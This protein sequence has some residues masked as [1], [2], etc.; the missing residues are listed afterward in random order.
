MFLT[1]AFVPSFRTR[2]SAW[3][4]TQASQQI[5]RPDPHRVTVVFSTEFSQV[6]CM[7]VEEQLNPHRGI[8]ML[9]G[10]G[11]R[12]VD[13]STY[14]ILTTL[15]WWCRS[16]PEGSILNLTEIMFEPAGGG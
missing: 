13:W 11:D 6:F 9:W 10:P 12:V 15:A 8:I 5:L 14:G 2:R 3:E 16:M 4:C 1:S 7:D